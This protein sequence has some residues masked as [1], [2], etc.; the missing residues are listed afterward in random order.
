M[1]TPEPFDLTRFVTAQE[2]V[3]KR[4][5]RELRAGCKQSH[6]MW[7]M[8][9]Q[10]RGLGVSAMAQHFG[11]RSLA[12]AQAYLAHPLLGP[13]LEE[14]TRLALGHASTPLRQIFG[15]PDDL[16]FRSCLTLFAEVAG[17]DS[18]YAE[19]LERMCGGV[20]DPTTLELIAR[21]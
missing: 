11:I 8:F 13:R 16:K 9:P 21:G 2:G 20:A 15:S 5:C 6:W 4:A 10:M 3:Y 14:A 1:S 19:A 17:P 12:E 7:F 18:V